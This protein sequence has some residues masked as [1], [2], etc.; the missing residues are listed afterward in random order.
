MKWIGRAR[1]PAEAVPCPTCGALISQ[2]CD[3][4]VFRGEHSERAVRAEAY[5]F[6]AVADAQR[7]L[8]LG[9]AA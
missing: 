1:T 3:N 2:P 4:A 7:E 8:A 9:D 5:G 6:V